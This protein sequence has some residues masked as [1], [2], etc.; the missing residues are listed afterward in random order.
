MSGTWRMLEYLPQNMPQATSD[1]Y[2]R[3]WTIPRGANRV[4]PEGASVHWSVFRQGILP[5][6]LPK[7]YEID[8]GGQ[9]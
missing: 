2:K 6:N 9:C 1:G 4:I 5:E 3:R 7:T 8:E